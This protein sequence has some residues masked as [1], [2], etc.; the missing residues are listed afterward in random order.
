MAELADRRSYPPELAAHEW[1][2][3]PKAKAHL[4]AK[5]IAVQVDFSFSCA[6]PYFVSLR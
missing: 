2:P 5:D 3:K 6:T 1:L 4:S